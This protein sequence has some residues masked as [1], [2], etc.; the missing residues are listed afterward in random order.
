M[1]NIRPLAIRVRKMRKLLA[2]AASIVLL[3]AAPAYAQMSLMGVGKVRAVGGGGG[4]Y[5]GPGDLTSGWAVWR[6]PRAFS[7][8]IA[9]A[10]TQ[11]LFNLLRASDSHTCDFLVATSGGVGNSANC[12]SVG[13]NAQSLATW[14][15]ATTG[16]VATWYDQ[17][18][19]G[20]DATGGANPPSLTQSCAGTSLPCL[21]G[22]GFTTSLTSS[23]APVLSQ[24]YSVSVLAERTGNVSSYANIWHGA[25]TGFSSAQ[26]GYA[27]TSNTVFIG[28]ADV[29][30]SATD[31]TQHALNGVLNGASSVLNVDGTETTGTVTAGGTGTTYCLFSFDCSGTSALTGNI[32]EFGVNSTAFSG[33]VRTNL[34]NNQRTYYG[35]AGSC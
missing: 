19:N 4:G 7:A 18:G 15:A 9:A 2:V 31:N 3:L 16:T 24:G 33:T 8:A 6:G 35:L 22:N 11:K 34:C 1:G 5:T 13:D 20:H 30:A 12:S 28:N 26:L 29:T 14:L 25:D 32:S 17:T 21:V 27:N 10:G 23:S